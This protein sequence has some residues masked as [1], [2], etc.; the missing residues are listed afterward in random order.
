MTLSLAAGGTPAEYR[1]GL[2]CAITKGWLWRHESGVY[3][4]RSL[5]IQ[6]AGLRLC[7]TATA[8]GGLL[9]EAEI[10]RGW[11]LA[12]AGRRTACARGRMKEDR[13]L[14]RPT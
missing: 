1:D 7:N 11:P 14:R 13:Q 12:P 3:G 10:N 2:D 5:A 6:A 4:S 9:F 8:F